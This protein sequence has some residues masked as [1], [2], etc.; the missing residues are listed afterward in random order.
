MLDHNNLRL[1]F[2]FHGSETLVGIV[3]DLMSSIVPHLGS[4]NDVEARVL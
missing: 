1:I 4:M 3:C 2:F